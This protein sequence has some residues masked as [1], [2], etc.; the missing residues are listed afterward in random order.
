[1]RMTPKEFQKCMKGVF[2]LLLTP[3]DDENRMNEAALREQIDYVKTHNKGEDLVFLA[4]GSTAEFYA[5]NDEEW[6]RYV[7]VVV[8]EVAGEFPVLMGCGQAGTSYTIERCKIAEK[9]GVDA[10][11]IVNPYYHVCTLEGLFNHIR[12]IAKETKL[13]VVTYNNPY[14]SKL[15]IPPELMLRLSKIE[16]VVGDK[17]NANIPM[18]IIKMM[19]T[20]DPDDMVIFNGLGF[21]MFQ[22]VAMYGCPGYVTEMAS[23]APE[24]A[25]EIYKAGVARN[26][27]AMERAC[28]KA[29][30]VFD[31]TG[32]IIASRS[33]IPTVEAPAAI[34]YGQPFYQSIQKKAQD[35][36]GLTGGRTR[37]PME[38]NLTEAEV[39][40]LRTILKTM[41]CKVVR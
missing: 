22:F 28:L 2:D 16:N 4:G 27:E 31:F 21:D 14:P 23:Y 6:K 10:V 35:L 40:E 36:V 18:P 13:G 29:Q 32:K 12:A 17:E 15:W 25:Q 11:M 7:E 20:I 24:L 8:D 33:G 26:P 39:D 38:D 19:R 41:G 37:A 30:P 9:T 3:F 34:S 5:M 1:M